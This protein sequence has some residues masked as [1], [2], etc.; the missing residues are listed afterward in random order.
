[1]A[2]TYERKETNDEVVIVHKFWVLFYPVVLMMLIIIF[3]IGSR[4]NPLIYLFFV[5]FFIIFLI[6]NWAPLRET[7]KAVET[8]TAQIS[9]SKFSFSNPYTVKIKKKAGK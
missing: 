5:L 1:M 8:G 2:L 3:F 9:G 4:I 6:D 7:G